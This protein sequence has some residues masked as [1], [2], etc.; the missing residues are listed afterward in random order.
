MADAGFVV[1]AYT[2]RGFGE[3]SGEISM[4]SPQFEVSDAS[5][6]VTYLSSLASVTQDS[7]GDPVVGVAGGS[8]GGALALLLAGYDRRIDAV[9]ADITWNDL[10]TSLF[11][12]STVDATSPGV[13]KSMWTSVFFSSGLGFAPGQPV[14]ECGRFT[15]DW[16]AAYVEAATDGAVS[17]A[18]SALM[19]ASSP[20]CRAVR[21]VVPACAG[22]CQRAADHKRSAEDGV[23]RRRSRRRHSRDRPPSTSYCTVVRCSPAWW[24]RGE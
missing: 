9:A 14:T 7:D 10:E 24:P 15:R 4:N 21:L 22:E 1:L 5:A 17:D 18:S 13:L 12:Q 3:S 23:A 2:A 8:Y 16:C 6:L 11:A 19:A 20:K